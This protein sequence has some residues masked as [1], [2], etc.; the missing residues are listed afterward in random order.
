MNVPKLKF[1]KMNLQENINTIKWAYYEDN[2]VLSVRD[3]TIQYFPQLADLD[4]N[5]SQQEV[6]K[7]IEQV[8]TEDYE[9]YEKRIEQ[10][11]IRYNH[12]WEKYNDIYFQNLENYLCVSWP[13]NLNV[14]D[15][16]VGLIPVFPRYLDSFSF[17]VSTGVED[18]KI[19]EVCAHET[20]HLLWFEKWKKMYPEIPRREYDSPFITWQYSEMVTD[21]VLNNQPFSDMFPFHEYGYDSFYNMYDGDVLVMD[22]LREIYSEDI[23][24]EN[25]INKGFEYINKV[26]E[27]ENKT[28]EKKDDK[29]KIW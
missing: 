2:G 8:V 6:Y 7:I 17:S 20:L 19:I 5:L 27:K 9:K 25:K 23:G 15:G 11:V 24:I 4:E 12:L 28:N 26:I 21:P 14:I 16:K 10:E 13:K 29:E 3:F 1:K 18:W 22:R